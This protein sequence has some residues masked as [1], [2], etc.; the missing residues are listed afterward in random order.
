MGILSVG[1]FADGSAFYGGAWN[2]VNGAVKG[3][4]YGDGSQLIAQIIGCITLIVWAFGASYVFFKILNAIIPMRVPANVELEGLDIEET[5]VLAYPEF[6]IAG[7][8]TAVSPVPE[9][10]SL[11]TR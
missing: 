3:L 11:E 2:G 8:G 1:L 9:G 7:R 10:V 5:G 4:F 6:P